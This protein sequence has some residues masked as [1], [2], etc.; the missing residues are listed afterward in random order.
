MCARVGDDCVGEE[1]ANMND[2]SV[3]SSQRRGR[4]SQRGQES[5]IRVIELK[6]GGGVVWRRARHRA[7]LKWLNQGLTKSHDNIVKNQIGKTQVNPVLNHVPKLNTNRTETS[8][9]YA[10][11]NAADVGCSSR[12]VF[13]RSS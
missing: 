13:L 6:E 2:T 12:H 3:G 10:Q 9:N 8:R 1:T 11:L 5:R 4:R 7:H